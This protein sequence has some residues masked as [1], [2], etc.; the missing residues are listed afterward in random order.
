MDT[1]IKLS[2]IY[3]SQTDEQIERINQTLEIYLQHYVNH[4]QKNWI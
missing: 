1:K 3:Y 4:S 2:I